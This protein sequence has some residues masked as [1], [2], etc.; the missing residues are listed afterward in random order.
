MILWI[1]SSSHPTHME[2]ARVLQIRKLTVLRESMN[3]FQSNGYQ[4]SPKLVAYAKAMNKHMASSLSLEVAR[5]C[6]FTSELLQLLLTR[7]TLQVDS[8][9]E[10]NCG[11]AASV[12]CGVSDVSH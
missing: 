10:Q 5:F 12:K 11:S 6:S 4:V 2:L 9:R 8:P 7:H 3:L 1:E